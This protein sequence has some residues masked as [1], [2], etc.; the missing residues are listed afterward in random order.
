[1]SFTLSNQL[2][3][4]DLDFFYQRTYQ[5]SL[6]AGLVPDGQSLKAFS[7]ELKAYNH[8]KKACTV[9]VANAADGAPAGYIWAANRGASDELGLLPDLAWVY[10][11]QVVPEF[12]R[13]GLGRLL[14]SQAEDWSRQ[15]GYTHLGLHVYGVNHGAIRLYETSGFTTIS[16]YLRK[17]LSAEDVPSPIPN[18]SL[19]PAA[20]GEDFTA[21]KRISLEH[22]AHL[23]RQVSPI[24]AEQIA[25]NHA[26]YLENFRFDA[27][28]HQILLLE[29]FNGAV[30]GGAWFY[31]SKGDMG[32]TPYLWVQEAI[33]PTTDLTMKLFATLEHWAVNHDLFNIRTLRMG[34]ERGLLQALQ[35]SGFNISNLFMRKTLQTKPGTTTAPCVS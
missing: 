9:I 3:P 26:A 33:A 29:D 12:R 4:Q 19:R 22:F 14:L 18:L 8:S 35:S 15:Q 34:S 20:T 2:S 17:A 23:T 21:Y 11:I 32:S 27:E 13:R 30:V 10:D 28:K 24:S 25:T 5:S 31:P 7:E 16:C 1:M 6:D